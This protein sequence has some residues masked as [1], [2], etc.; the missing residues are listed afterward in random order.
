MQ[1]HHGPPGMGQHHPGPPGSGGQPPPRPPP[2]M[3]HPGP[4]PMGMPPRGPHFGSPMGK[5]DPPERLL[6]GFGDL[7]CPPALPPRGEASGGSE[8]GV[9]R[10]PCGV[11]LLLQ[12][13][14]LPGGVFPVSQA[15]KFKKGGVLSAAASFSPVWGSW[16]GSTGQPCGPRSWAPAWLGGC[17]G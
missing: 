2:G 10:I 7:W 12:E 15:G 11:G 14:G 16:G 6:G 8:G 4:P 13:A 9:S 5:W 17:G 3:P 1:V